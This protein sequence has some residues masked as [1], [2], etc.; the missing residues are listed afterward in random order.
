V[1][2]PLGGLLSLSAWGFAGGPP[3]GTSGAPGERTCGVCHRGPLALPNSLFIETGPYWPG[4]PHSIRLRTTDVGGAY[5]FQVSMRYWSG[6]LPQAGTFSPRE[7]QRVV[8]SSRNFER[9][10]LREGRFCPETHPLEYLMH[11]NPLAAPVVEIEW[12]APARSSEPVVF[13]VAFNSV[14]ADGSFGGDRFQSTAVM[15]PAWTSRRSPRF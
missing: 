13:Y 11:A 8:C 9:E 1:A 5:G 10:I 4:Q 2:G 12:N 6:A 3:A 7:G 15:I 14:N